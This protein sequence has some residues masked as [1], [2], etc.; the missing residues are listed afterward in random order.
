LQPRK[1]GG[2]D[3]GPG[4]AADYVGGYCSP[5]PDDYDITVISPSNYFLYTPLLP[6][7]TV[8]TLEVR[9]RIE[10]IRTNTGAI[11]GHF[12]KANAES[13]DLSEK[14]VE[15]SQVDPSGKKRFLYV[16]YDKLVIGVDPGRGRMESRDC[17]IASF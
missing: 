15:L 7:A 12:M 9:S 10:P 2:A 14:L 8:G 3:L 16:P 4:H 1:T 13:V 17:G 5:R 6:S 11:R